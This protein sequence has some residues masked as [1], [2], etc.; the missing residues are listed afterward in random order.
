M[1]V[2]IN[3]LEKLLWLP[4]SFSESIIATQGLVGPA[5]SGPGLVTPVSPGRGSE[6]L[7]PG[8]FIFPKTLS[9]NLYRGAF[10]WFYAYF[11][12]DNP[13]YLDPLQA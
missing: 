2:F 4:F 5:L 1:K 3:L 7:T 10:T 8:A 12:A 6:Q 11:L 9:D 13:G